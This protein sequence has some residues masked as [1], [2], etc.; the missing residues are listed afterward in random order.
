M[1]HRKAALSHADHIIV[2]KDGTIEAEGT[3]SQLLAVSDS[4]RRLWH[5]EDSAAAAE[6]S[7][8]P[9]GAGR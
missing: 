6:P 3:A 5:G 4:F 8:A 1:S 9:G 7:A 2:L